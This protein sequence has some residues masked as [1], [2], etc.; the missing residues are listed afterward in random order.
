MV[1]VL[2]HLRRQR[3][4]LLAIL[5]QAINPAEVT[6]EGIPV[7]VHQVVMAVV[8]GE[9]VIRVVDA[10]AVIRWE[11][12]A[13]EVGG[14]VAASQEAME[15]AVFR[16]IQEVFLGVAVVFQAAFR[17]EAA[18]AFRVEEAVGLVLRVEVR[19]EVGLIQLGTTEVFLLGSVASWLSK[20]R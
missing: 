20:S 12:V 14:R 3:Q 18:A 5:N 19:Q 10:K 15:V 11:L 7:V 9:V 6:M 1:R 16:E 17:V 8:T 13:L 4:V 2:L